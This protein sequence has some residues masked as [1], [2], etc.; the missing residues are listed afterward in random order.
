MLF[1]MMYDKNYLT[2]YVVNLRFGKK[3]K[4][5]EAI[6]DTACS[7]TLAPLTFAKQCGTKLNHSGTIV[8]GGSSYK[9]NLH[10]FENAVLGG[11]TIPKLVAF[12]AD[13]KGAIADRILLGNNVLYNFAIELH[14]TENGRINFR[15][16]P[17]HLVKDTKHPCAMFFRT[18]DSNPVYPSDM[19]M[20]EGGV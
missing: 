6:L 10:L 9:A 18:L 4:A 5:I 14:R 17:W 3:G 15:Y 1:S 8:V 11:F 13:Y 16:E 7:T 19:I 2:R 20:E 12:A